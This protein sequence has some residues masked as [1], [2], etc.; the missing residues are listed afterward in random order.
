MYRYSR[1]PH[2][3]ADIA[4]IVGW[5]V[6]CAS[7]GAALVGFAGIAVLIAAL[8]AE[9]PWLKAQYGSAFEDYQAKVRRFL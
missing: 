3:V 8:F 4:M 9:E 6:L 7:A 5:I 2:Y 1:N